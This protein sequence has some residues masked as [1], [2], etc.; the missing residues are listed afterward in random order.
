MAKKDIGVEQFRKD[1][2][3]KYIK[4]I[5]KQA[6]AIQFSK[7]FKTDDKLDNFII[8]PKQAYYNNH[9]L[10]FPYVNYFI[11]FYDT[12]NEL[13]TAY[14][15]IKFM[16]D[17]KNNYSKELFFD[18]LYEYILSDTMV[19]K[20]NRMVD[21]NYVDCL[22]A[23]RE[24]N[25]KSI[26]F[27]DEHGKI[28]LASSMA[29]KM[30][31]PLV[32]HYIAKMGVANTD[33]FLLDAF[34]DVFKYFEGRNNIKNKLY[35]FVFSKVNKTQ[36]RDKGHWTKVE[37]EG[38]DIESETT[39]IYNRIVVDI[40]YKMSFEG[41]IAAL[42][43]S[44]IN[45]NVNWMLRKKFG[46]NRKMLTGQKDGDGLSDLDKIEMNMSKMDE[47]FIIMGDINTKHVIKKLKK[48]FKVKITDDEVEY[49]VENMNLN[50]LQEDLIF[51]IFAS[52]FG[53]TRD[54]Q[55]SVAK[56]EMAKLIIIMKKMMEMKGF[57]IMQHILSGVMFYDP[58]LRKLS[59]KQLNII[60]ES[61][62]YAFIKKKYK[63]T[64]NLV[65]ETEHFRETLNKIIN[66]DVEALDYKRKD[67]E[68][69]INME[70]YRDV[71]LSEY[72]KMIEELI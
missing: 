14:Y 8:K 43:S 58:N 41:N 61:D 69:N 37:I 45:R 28:L 29:I 52:Y 20:I 17:R 48:K 24:Y 16:I 62:K 27:T 1:T 31:I 44:A 25:H 47:S 22:A 15:K 68:N 46:R 12:D 7:I 23:K 49:Y 57:I 42:L 36:S 33:L 18:E 6:V 11:E 50:D 9:D 13:L 4:N 19:E 32:T 10:I 26:Q 54:M 56:I 55:H 51:Q 34:V 59:K 35:E 71:I 65:L 70:K 21:E 53:C 40:T 67:K 30:F 63:Y 5:S 64:A 72:M 3:G 66:S 2:Y 60:L 38:E 39:V